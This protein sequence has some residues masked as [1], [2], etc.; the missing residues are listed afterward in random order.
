M[1]LFRYELAGAGWAD[2]HLSDGTASVEIPAS[3]TSVMRFVDLVDAIQS[4]FTTNSAECVWQEELR[5]SEMDFFAEG[6]FNRNPGRV[7]E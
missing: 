5:R 4:L 7:V 2:A 3:Y 1:I 6:R